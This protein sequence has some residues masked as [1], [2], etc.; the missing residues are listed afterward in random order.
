MYLCVKCINLLMSVRVRVGDA[1]ECVCV[2]ALMHVRMCVGNVS[3]C[4]YVCVLVMRVS[5][6]AYVR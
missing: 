6:C 4:V 1:S 2:C 5:A 3:E